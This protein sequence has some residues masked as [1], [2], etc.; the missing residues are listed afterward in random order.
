MPP[1]L[2]LALP[3]PLPP[4]LLPPTPVRWLCYSALLCESNPPARAAA[5]QRH[6]V[7]IDGEGRLSS[8]GNE[9]AEGEEEEEEDE[10]ALPGLLGHGEGVTRLNTP[11]RLPSMLGDERAERLGWRWTQPRP[12]RRRRC[13]EL[14]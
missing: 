5:G 13:L 10:M 4:P 7:F 9:A 3:P 11:T 8:C 2:S 1:P 12:H 14:G 6:S